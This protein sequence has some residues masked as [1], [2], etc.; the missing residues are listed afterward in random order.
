M[1]MNEGMASPRWLQRSSP[2]EAPSGTQR[3]GRT[4][5]DERGRRRP[6]TLAVALP[7]SALR[8]RDRSG[9]RQPRNR[10]GD[11]HRLTKRD[12]DDA[13]VPSVTARPRRQRSCQLDYGLGRTHGH[14][15]N[16]GARVGID[17]GAGSP[18]SSD[19]SRLHWEGD[20]QRRSRNAYHS[21]AVTSS[22][23]RRAGPP[24]KRG[25][26]TDAIR[27]KRSA[28]PAIASAAIF[29]PSVANATPWPE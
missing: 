17:V 16:V 14:D 8:F 12:S 5:R 29:P 20:P 1:G 7:F 15:A 25:V 22:G 6:T 13:R 4:E 19:D 23:R 26:G 2:K 18:K 21:M 3:E 9:F 10:T 27:S 28:W 11:H 24:G